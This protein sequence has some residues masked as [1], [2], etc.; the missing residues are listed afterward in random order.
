M[1]HFD[2]RITSA[3]TLQ[4][5]IAS[6]KLISENHTKNHKIW[7]QNLQKNRQKPTKTYKIVGFEKYFRRL[8]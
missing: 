8:L 6:Y 7:S 1:I 2:D 3:V 4:N 5:N